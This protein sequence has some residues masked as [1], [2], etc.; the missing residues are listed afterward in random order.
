M[1]NCLL[2][3]FKFFLVKSLTISIFYRLLFSLISLLVFFLDSKLCINGY[4]RYKYDIRL[5]IKCTQS[6]YIINGFKKTEE[7]RIHIRLDTNL[8]I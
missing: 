6:A 4:F 1:D 7:K 8:K 2:L 3:E 5:S